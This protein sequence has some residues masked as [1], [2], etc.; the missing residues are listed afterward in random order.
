[1][2]ALKVASHLA[3]GAHCQKSPIF[4]QMSPFISF[5]SILV[6]LLRPCAALC[7]SVLQC[8]AVCCSVLQCVA[9]CCSVSTTVTWALTWASSALVAS[10]STQ[11]HIHACAMTHLFVRMYVHCCVCH[12][13]FVCVAYLSRS[14]VWH[15]SLI[16][17]TCLLH[18]CDRTHP[19]VWNHGY[20]FVTRSQTHVWQWIIH[21]SVFALRLLLTQI[22]S[23]YDYIITMIVSLSE[24]LSSPR[25]RARRHQ[26]L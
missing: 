12:D 2:P 16:F 17:L 26:L 3:P 23:Q 15:F 20:V 22:M 25:S 9:V 14:H 18:T 19:K 8:V 4:R 6:D 13:V 11:E 24:R 1:M 7:C 21:T 5:I 10:T